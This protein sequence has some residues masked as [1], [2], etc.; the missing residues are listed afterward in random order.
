MITVTVEYG[1]GNSRTLQ[2]Q[3]GSTVGQVLDSTRPALGFGQSVKASIDGAIQDA[4]ITVRDG[5]H[6]VV[7]SYANE[8]HIL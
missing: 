3:S 7:E 5:D 1:C 8:K 2:V 6:I 4:G